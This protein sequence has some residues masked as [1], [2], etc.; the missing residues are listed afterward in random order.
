MAAT[1]RL[2]QEG[3]F[4]ETD[5]RA[6]AMANVVSSVEVTDENNAH[7]VEIMFHADRFLRNFAHNSID[8]DKPPFRVF[9]PK[10]RD[11]FRFLLNANQKILFNLILDPTTGVV[12]GTSNRL[13]NPFGG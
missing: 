9:L 4:S 7:H 2:P 10:R 1:Q 5:L 6:A 11:L 12:V 8:E 13:E 3:D